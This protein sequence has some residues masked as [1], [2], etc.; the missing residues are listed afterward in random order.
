MPAAVNGI[1]YTECYTRLL[2]YVLSGGDLVTRGSLDGVQL[3]ECVATFNTPRHLNITLARYNV[4]TQHMQGV[5]MYTCILENDII[6]WECAFVYNHLMLEH[7]G[8][9]RSCTKSYYMLLL[10]ICFLV[11]TGLIRVCVK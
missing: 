1:H 10:E 11:Y 6:K 7:V 4:T 5:Y 2:Q 9:L 3:Y 8:C